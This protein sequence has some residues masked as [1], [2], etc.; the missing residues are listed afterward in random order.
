MV[1]TMSTQPHIELVKGRSP[2]TS[3]A[4]LTNQF[5]GVPTSNLWRFSWNGD[6]MSFKQVLLFFIN[7]S[8]GFVFFFNELPFQKKKGRLKILLKKNSKQGQ[9][10]SSY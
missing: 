1:V 2:V 10:D 7:R 5:K 4:T 8:F 3:W 9:L 6:F